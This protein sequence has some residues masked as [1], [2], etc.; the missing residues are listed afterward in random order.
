MKIKLTLAFDGSAYH[1]WRSQPS[2]R[3]VQD[4]VEAALARVFPG[5]PKLESSSRT[6]AGVHARGL[7]AHFSLSSAGPRLTPRALALALNSTLPADIRVR[8]AVRVP[9]RFHAR[10]D[11]VEKEYR[12][13][14]WNAP[15][16][17]PLRRH[18]AWH[19]PRPLDIA[20]MREAARHFAGRHDFT[21]FTSNRGG[22][23]G[24][25]YRTLTRCEIRREGSLVTIRL[26]ASGFLYKLCRALAGTLVHVGEKKI[27]PDEIPRLLAT[28][29]RRATGPNAPAHGLVLWRVVY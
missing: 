12:Y 15:A 7:V 10:F 21:A 1:G 20:R 11:A 2:G 23:L 25:P 6:D 5:G 8:S 3:G 17:D 13:F 14:I 18:T 4:Q 16:M 28:R 26:A 19:V 9:E 27:A 22:T 24:D 29:D